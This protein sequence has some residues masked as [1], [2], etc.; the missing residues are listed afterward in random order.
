[1]S[2]QDVEQAIHSVM[3]T[4]ANSGADPSRRETT[5]RHTMVDPIL[6]S[7]GWRTWIPWEC[8]QDFELRHRVRVD[9][10]L[11]DPAEEPA[12]VIEVGT[13]PARRA[14]DR[15]R[16]QGGVRGTRVAVAVL[17]YG[18]EWEIYDLEHRTRRFVDKRAE[19]LL[20]DYRVPGQVGQT[21]TALYSWLGKDRW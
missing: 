1:M 17:T 10:A 15:V 14:Q 8:Q 9:Y 11:F 19:R 20:L 2:A 3:R 21:A 18:W 7:L 5:L 13:I 4:A 16:L 12:I 6:W